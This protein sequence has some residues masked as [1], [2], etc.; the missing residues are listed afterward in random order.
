MAKLQYPDI[1][2]QEQKF[3]ALADLSLRLNKQD[4][5]HIT[6]TLVDLIDDE[7]TD[8]IAEKW[9]ATGYDGMFLA[10]ANKNKRELIK[11]SIELHRLKGTPWSIREV[12]RCLGLGEVI[13]DEGLKLRDYKGNSFVASIPKNE[14]WAHFGVVLEK[15]ITNDKIEEVKKVIN[16]FKPARCILAILDYKAA[17]ILYNNKA[18]YNG[19]YNYGSA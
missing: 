18:R 2:L 19:K 1:I 9:S 8:L 6:T 5:S 10:T 7:F 11:K 15:P 4:L 16:N 17:A 14:I 12:L 3:T 13:I